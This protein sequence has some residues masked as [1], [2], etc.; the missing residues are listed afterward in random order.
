LGRSR[1]PLL[2]VSE[3]SVPMSANFRGLI[4]AIRVIRGK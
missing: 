2:P 4:P 3:K 1:E